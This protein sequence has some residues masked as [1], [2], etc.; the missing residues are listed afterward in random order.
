MSLEDVFGASAVG[1]MALFYALEKRSPKFLLA[2]AAACLASAGY[3]VVIRSWPFAAV[4]FLWASIAVRRWS[5]TRES[6]MRAESDRVDSCRDVC[7]LP[8]NQLRERFTLLRRDVLSKVMARQRLQEGWALDFV[9]TPEMARALEDIV[10]VERECCSSLSWTLERAGEDTLRLRIEGLSP[11]S[12][13]FDAM[14]LGEPDPARAASAGRIP[15]IVAAGGIGALVSFLVCCGGP[16]ALAVVAGGAVAAPFAVLDR[17]LFVILG[18]IT[19]GIPIWF[20]LRR[21][22]DTRRQP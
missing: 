19:A 9:Y 3:A 15:R 21:R 11:D 17:P 13:F 12:E 7:T 22:D 4:E 14:G 20:W 18:A 8:G 5:L 16:V 10:A 2:F 1:A 6:R